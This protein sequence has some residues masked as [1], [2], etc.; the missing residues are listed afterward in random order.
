MY[1]VMYSMHMGAQQAGKR[2]YAG[3]MR[4]GCMDALMY[5]ALPALIVS[6]TL[7]AL[8]IAMV[9]RSTRLAVQNRERLEAVASKLLERDPQEL[10]S[11]LLLP[12]RQEASVMM[13]D[14]QKLLGQLNSAYGRGMALL[15]H[16]GGATGDLQDVEDKPDP[17]EDV[18]RWMAHPLAPIF[19]AKM[20]INL[21][22]V[23]QALAAGVPLEQLGMM[24]AQKANG[25]APNDDLL[26]G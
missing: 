16:Y 18:E 4:D 25:G 10:A 8:T 15:R 11:R 3:K 7:A 6:C 19:A 14:G 2:V 17:R 21:A 1:Y 12:V 23:R 22:E 20:G 9:R 26:L 24:V 5:V 13:A